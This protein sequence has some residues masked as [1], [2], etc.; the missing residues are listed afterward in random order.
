MNPP[1]FDELD[2]EAARRAL[3]YYL[4]PTPHPVAVVSDT[5]LV[6]ARK[7]LTPTEAAEH[8]ANLLRCAAA[9]AFCSADMLKGASRD[10]CYTVMHMIN[11][12]RALLD[13]SLA[14]QAP[15]PQNAVQEQMWEE[16]A[17]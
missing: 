8:A 2:S 15:A 12:A 17:T 6:I 1:P 5:P 11:M 14:E 9:T 3:D 4:N 13:R 10:A 7:D 16:P